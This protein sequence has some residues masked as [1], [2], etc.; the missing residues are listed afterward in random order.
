MNKFSVNLIIKRLSGLRGA[1]YESFNFV[2]LCSDSGVGTYFK[3]IS[4]L[5]AEMEM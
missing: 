4:Q 1:E 5:F 3:T 2:W